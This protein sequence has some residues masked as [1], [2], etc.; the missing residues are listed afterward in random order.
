MCDLCFTP[1]MF[2]FSNIY[3]FNVWLLLNPYYLCCDWSLGSIPLVHQ[4]NDLR[5]L[6][7]LALYLILILLAGLVLKARK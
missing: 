3:T 2:S 6:A 1:R 4:W 5:N 7:S